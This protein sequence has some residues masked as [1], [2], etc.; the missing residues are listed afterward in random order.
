MLALHC[1]TSASA[2][3]KADIAHE[4]VDQSAHVHG[5]VVKRIE[6]YLQ[7]NKN[8]IPPRVYTDLRN[9]LVEHESDNQER[10]GRPGA[11]ATFLKPRSGQHVGSQIPVTVQIDDV[12]S[13][14]HVWIAVKRGN[15]I[16]P[17]EPEILPSGEKWSG[18]AFEGG[19]P[20]KLDLALISVNEKAHQR[21]LKWFDHGSRTGSFP[22]L[23]PHE[24]DATCLDVVENLELQ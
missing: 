22:G 5:S 24:L 16:W 12:A 21:I 17:K 23:T 9:I 8:R 3:D 15:L 10:E 13:G 20:G 14:Y 19:A 4:T 7:Q 1:A 6:S 2:K 18:I 11:T